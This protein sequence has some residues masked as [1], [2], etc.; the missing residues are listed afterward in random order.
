MQ[1]PTNCVRKRS[2]TRPATTQ[3]RLQRARST[4]QASRSTSRSVNDE[5]IHVSAGLVEVVAADEGDLLAIGRPGGSRIRLAPRQ[6]RALA[7]RGVHY[8]EL[9]ERERGRSHHGRG[10][11]WSAH[12]RDA[13]PVWR[14]GGLPGGASVLLARQ[15]PDFA[16]VRIH[17]EH[18]VV[19]EGC[20]FADVLVTGECDL[21]TVR[22]PRGVGGG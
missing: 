5:E 8:D 21:T 17:H 20:V 19:C 6:P 12:V 10:Y 1:S 22:R 14:P 18:V 13:P 7:S 2:A 9:S 15:L 16:A 3:A 11:R 4:R